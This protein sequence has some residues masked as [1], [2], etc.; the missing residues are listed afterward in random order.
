MGLEAPWFSSAAFAALPED[1]LHLFG[2]DVN[3]VVRGAG[4]VLKGFNG[5]DTSLVIDPYTACSW[6]ANGSNAA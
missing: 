1:D 5:V 2:V 4:D 3:G 6:P